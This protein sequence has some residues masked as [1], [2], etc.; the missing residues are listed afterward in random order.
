[1]AKKV[2]CSTHPHYS[3]LPSSA[4]PS[5]DVVSALH[6]SHLKMYFSAGCSSI[7]LTLG[8]SG[9]LTVL[10]DRHIL[11]SLQTS[12]FPIWQIIL[13]WPEE[14]LSLNLLESPF[15]SV[16]THSILFPKMHI[17]SNL[18]TLFFSFSMCPSLH[19]WQLQFSLFVSLFSFFFFFGHKHSIFLWPRYRALFTS[20]LLIKTPNVQQTIWFKLRDPPQSRIQA[21]SPAQTPQERARIL[22]SPGLRLSPSVT[23]TGLQG[24]ETRRELALSSSWG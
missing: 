4:S 23:D 18:V 21:L 7:S 11:P 16:D 1:M 5:W 22:F 15:F 14:L 8:L 17:Y 9:N 20:P 13:F 6:F 24:L 3:G 2:V 12:Q 10:W 19:T